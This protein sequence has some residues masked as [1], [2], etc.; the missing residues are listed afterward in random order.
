MKNL[1]LFIFSFFLIL[2]I[3]AQ[4]K[5]AYEIFSAS[6]KK[7]SFPKLVKKVQATNVLFF[8]E[9]HNNPIAHW[10]TFEL[11]KTL[12]TQRKLIIGA[13]MFESDQQK[14]LNRY[15]QDSIDHK[16]LAENIKLWSNY[17]TDYKPLVDFAKAK[18]IP[19]IATNVP[20]KYA[21]LAHKRGLGIL[22]NLIDQE[23]QYIAP[24]PMEFD[25]NLPQYQKILETMGDHGTPNLV[26]AQ[27]LRDATMAHYIA[28]N[29]N[30]EALFF[31]LNGSYHSNYKEGI[32]WYLHKYNPN[33]SVMTIS[34]V[35]QDDIATLKEEHFNKADFIICVP[36]S[37]TKT[38]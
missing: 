34:V 1:V 24:Q 11:I 16:L 2:K 19:V 10:L 18:K 12:S 14:E 8:G 29:Y 20:G 31:H 6:G 23:Q 25:I 17:D 5:K 27:A 26:M 3:E 32:L 28:E 38:Y 13:E 33:L 36:N 37:M 21:R 4:H 30:E 15:L 9:I 35:E 7:V 22:K